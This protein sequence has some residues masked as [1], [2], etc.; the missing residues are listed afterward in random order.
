MPMRKSTLFLLGFACLSAIML[1]YTSQ[2]V[3]DEREKLTALEAQ[4]D[5]EQ[6]SMR[7]LSAEWSYL[8]QPDR[9][10][11]LARQHLHLEPLKGRQFAKL[12]DIPLPP[13]P[14][15]EEDIAETPVVDDV[16]AKKTATEDPVAEKPAVP[17]I[18]KPKISLSENAP[19]QSPPKA[20]IPMTVQT[21][22]KIP[23]QTAAPMSA[24]AAVVAPVVAIAPLSAKPPV[25]K[26]PI[27]TAAP[28]PVK[29]TVLSTTDSPPHRDFNDLMKSL[30]TP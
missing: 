10:E 26:R 17:Q 23:V 8:N 20:V 25:I 3:H 21:V 13:P 27:V 28:A 24:P 2:K 4:I 12:K 7:V 5:K 19:P 15:I 30:G 18:L 1:Y 16:A 14:V 11:K 9:L 29:K 6:E 22:T